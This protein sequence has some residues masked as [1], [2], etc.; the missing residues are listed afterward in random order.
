MKSSK[1]IR[2]SIHGNISLNE[3]EVELLDTPQ[4]QRLRSIRQ[5]GFC[6]LVYPAMNSTRF[7]HSL[8]VMHLA[9]KVARHLNLKSKN[10]QALRVA[11]LLH[12]VGHAAFSHTSDEI[13]LQNNIYHEERSAKIIQE[14]EIADILR[15]HS[16]DP[17]F[18]ADL[19]VGGGR[20]GKIIS[21]E[22]DVD[23]MDYLVRDA[24]YAG[25]TYGLTDLERVIESIKLNPHDVVVDQGGLEAVESLLIGRSLMYQAVYWHKTKRI[26]EAMFVEAVKQLFS[27]RKLS[28]KKYLAMD[29]IELISKLRG[30]RGLSRELMKRIDD[31]QLFKSAYK[32]KL[33]SLSDEVRTELTKKKE[34][35]REK[36]SADFSVKKGFVLLDVPESKLQEYKIK[37]EYDGQLHTIDEISNLASSLEQAEEGRLTVNVYAPQEEIKKFKKFRLEDYLP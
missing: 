34:R 17:S 3:L 15:R 28:M 1:I 5:N 11:G 7:E 20:L 12:D 33:H 21:S 18:V 37:I 26:A 6:F 35:I 29:D 2:D 9:G 30:S 10:P 13:L 8:G 25:V 23:K 31:R 19:V 22:I 16:L 32:V 14:T 36:I 27:K 24:H 4:V